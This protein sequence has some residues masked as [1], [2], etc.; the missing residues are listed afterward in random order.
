MTIL[1]R[2]KELAADASHLH[3]VTM[4]YIEPGKGFINAWDIYDNLKGIVNATT[5]KVE[6]G[7]VTYVDADGKEQTIS[8]DSVVICGGMEPCIDS[9]LSYVGAADIFYAVGDCNG[10]GNIQ[11]CTRDAFGKAM[12]L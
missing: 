2:Q 9:A 3:Y 7:T 4:C 1:T 8:G 10:A 6:G 5:T 12:M 11:K